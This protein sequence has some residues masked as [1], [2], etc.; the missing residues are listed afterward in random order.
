MPNMRA[1][2]M[3]SA[4]ERWRVQDITKPLIQQPTDLRVRVLA[5]GIN[6]VDGK[7]RQRGS[8]LAQGSPMIFGLDG[9]GIVEAVGEAVRHFSVGDGV[10]FC[11]GGLGGLEGTYAEYLVLDERLAVAKPRSTEF[12]TAAAAPLGLITAW[13]AL[14]DRAR[15]TSQQK[16]LI[17]GGAGGVGHLAIQMAK[18]KGAQVCTTISSEAKAHLASLWGADHCIYYPHMN[19]V[20]GVRYWTQG[21]GVD[22]AFDTVGEPILSQTFQA[23]C[24]GGD[25]VT[26]HSATPDTDWATARQRNLR[27]GFELTL[28]PRLH[29]QWEGL[30]H[31]TRILKQCAKW[32]D[33]GILTV[34]VDKTFPLE[35]VAAA[36]DYLQSGQAMGKVVLSLV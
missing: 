5:A 32:L 17:H 16:V 31:Q 23:I 28:T 22:I 19:F 33:S 4:G 9:A 8:Y 30:L 21:H 1:V 3:T 27:V 12:E 26:L 25:L 14:F 7:I 18:H 10:Y 13:E 20:D 24:Q 11:Y 29:Q 36:H 15:L 34:H 2:V 35:Q 6:P